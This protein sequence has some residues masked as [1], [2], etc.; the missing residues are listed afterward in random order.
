MFIGVT[1]MNMNLKCQVYIDTSIELYWSTCIS[2][3]N[4]KH[5][6]HAC[7]CMSGLC[8]CLHVFLRDKSLS[9]LIWFLSFDLKNHASWINSFLHSQRWRNLFIFKDL[10]ISGIT[11]KETENVHLFLYFSMATTVKLVP[12]WSKE[13]AVL[14]RSPTWVAET[15]VLGWSSAVFLGALTAAALEA[16]HERFGLWLSLLCHNTGPRRI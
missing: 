13:S 1:V 8:V 15:H 7:I 12:G 2:R 14:L 3:T 4:Y 9:R 11:E 10:C 6:I 16:Q 5:L